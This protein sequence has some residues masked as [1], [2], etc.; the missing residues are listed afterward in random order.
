M[1]G[2]TLDI[3]KGVAAGYKDRVNFVHVEPYQLQQTANGL[4]PLL[5][6]NGQLQ[7]VQSVFDYGLTS[8]PYM[9]VVDAA[10]NIA[11]KVEGIAGADEVKAMLDAVIASGG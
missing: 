6:A 1:C 8:E 4:Q 11:A 7:P 3:I 9:F 2:P 5:D 10:G